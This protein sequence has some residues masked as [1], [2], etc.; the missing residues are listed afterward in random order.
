[1]VNAAQDLITGF[2]LAGGDSTRMGSDKAFLQLGSET[3]LARAMRLAGAVTAEARIVGSAARFGRYGAVVEDI[4][5]KR[6]PLGGIHAALSSSATDMNL[7][8]AVDLPFV[9]LDF[10][11]YLIARACACDAVVTVPHASG[12]WQ[13]LCAVYRRAFAKTAE[14]ALMQGKNKIDALFV[15]VKTEVIGEDEL[16]GAGFSSAMFRNLNTPEDWERARHQL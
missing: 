12:G 15:S 5:P 13:P 6:G 10:L 8:L 4:F 16:T 3:L 14:A 2:V 11:K 9:E 7:V 1:M